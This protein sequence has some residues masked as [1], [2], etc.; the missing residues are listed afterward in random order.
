MEMRHLQHVTYLYNLQLQD[1]KPRL[2]DTQ[3]F[4]YKTQHYRNS[5]NR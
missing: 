1:Y 5:V 2:T 4:Y 3:V